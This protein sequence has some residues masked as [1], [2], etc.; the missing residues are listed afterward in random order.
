MYCTSELL[1]VIS[2]LRATYIGDLLVISLATKL[3]RVHP[4]HCKCSVMCVTL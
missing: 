3:T 4:I 1:V 2:L